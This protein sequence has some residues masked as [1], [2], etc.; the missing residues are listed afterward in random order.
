[1]MKTPFSIQGSTVVKTVL[2]KLLIYTRQKLSIQTNS[3]GFAVLVIIPH[4]Q[5]DPEKRKTK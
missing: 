3:T 2:I 4:Q 1:L 5:S